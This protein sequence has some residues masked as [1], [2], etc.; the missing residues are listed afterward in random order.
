MKLYSILRKVPREVNFLTALSVLTLLLKIL[1]L[2]E[3]NSPF[4]WMHDLG[5]VFK[6]V[7]VSII[8]SYV[9]FFFVVHIKEFSDKKIV[10]PYVT[11][12]SKRVVSEC[13]SQ[14]A[15]ITKNSDVELKLD[16][17]SLKDITSAFLKINPTS[18]AP[19]VF[20]LPDGYANWIQY[21]QFHNVRSKESINRVLGQLKFLEAKHVSLLVAID[22]CLHF[23]TM[24]HMQNHKINNADMSAFA[25]FF[26][27]YCELCKKLNTYINKDLNH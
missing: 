21:F 16:S 23:Q 4:N 9:F 3:L 8:A 26:F 10:S 13:I 27:D 22:D 1:F 14:L 20:F 6:D 19:L 2:D 12:H 15:D 7:L 24:N 11:K 17:L 18:K 5:N 25:S